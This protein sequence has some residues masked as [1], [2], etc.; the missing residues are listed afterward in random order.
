MV[1]VSVIVP[2]YNHAQFLDEALQSVLEQN[3][4]HWE[5]IIVN[6]GSLDHTEQV[7]NVWLEKDTRFKYVHQDN[8]GLANARNV[9]I[10]RAQGEFI[11]P[12][13]ADDKIS[14]DYVALALEAFRKN[15]SLKVVY[16]KAEKFG[17]ETGLWELKPFTLFNLSQENIIFC[18]A[19]YR[20]KDW[21]A[22]GGYDENMRYGCE[23]WE[24]WI[25]LLKQGGNVKQLEHV[26]FYYRTQQNSMLNN[27]SN[28]HY[29]Y[30]LDYLSIKHADFFV[31]QQGSFFEL[32]AKIEQVKKKELNKLKSEKYIIDVF[33]KRFLGFTLFGLYKVND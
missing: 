29:K 20:K 4:T 32:R 31:E 8:K 12:L 23:D 14:K 18:T 27:M 10:S 5:C 9:G 28:A 2:C 26:G 22:I 16:C 33:C 19:L 21:E 1:K 6:D 25:A 15:D 3:Y 17:A 24:F 13:D 11:L 7:A 30:S